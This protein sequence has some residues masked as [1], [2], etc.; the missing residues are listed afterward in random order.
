MSMT[1]LE[2]RSILIFFLMMEQTEHR[3]QVRQRGKTHS[4]R[5]SIS[6]INREET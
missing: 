1:V 5:N 6:G 2:R 3:V 4:E